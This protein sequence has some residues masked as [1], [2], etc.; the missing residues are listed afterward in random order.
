[1]PKATH[2]LLWVLVVTVPAERRGILCT[3]RGLFGPNFA[4]F[5]YTPE[6]PALKW[7]SMDN[8]AP[9]LF[10]FFPRGATRRR[11][12]HHHQ[13]LT[14]FPTH[15]LFNMDDDEPTLPAATK[16]PASD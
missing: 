4:A 15:T 10:S 1:M 9:T 6:P 11:E 3:L 16:P 2:T 14:D 12:T 13:H 8:A 5:K 7:C